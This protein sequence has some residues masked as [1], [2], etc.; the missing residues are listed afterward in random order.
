MGSTVFPILRANAAL[1]YEP[2]RPSACPCP[3]TLFPTNWD[4]P[5]FQAILSQRVLTCLFCRRFPMS[6]FRVVNDAGHYLLGGLRR[7]R[8]PYISGVNETKCVPR[9]ALKLTA[10]G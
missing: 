5:L 1:P 8:F 2:E 6:T 9:M 7:I 3:R 10:F 4:A